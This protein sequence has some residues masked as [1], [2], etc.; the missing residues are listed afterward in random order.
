MKGFG[1][2]AIT[3]IK[4]KYEKPNHY[5]PV[6]GNRFYQPS[7]RKKIEVC[8]CPEPERVDYA[9][10]CAYTRDK[11][12]ASEES[13]VNYLFQEILLKMSCVDLKN[14]SQETI[15][16]KVNCM[17]NKYRT[18]FACDSLGFNVP[19]GNVL[20]FTM[21]FNFP[22]FIYCM[23]DHYNVDFMFIDP[24][25]GK[26]IIMYLDEEISKTNKYG[27]GKIREM[28]EVRDYILSDK[29]YNPQEQLFEEVK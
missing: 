15:I 22:D 17:W 6:T 27:P 29:K 8:N 14:D 21:N 13:P 20:K 24:A 28:N 10:I 4:K 5:L 12:I 18:K 3:N 23:G 26:S 9:Q 1:S 11:K 16:Q 25:D 19:N 2:C 7:T